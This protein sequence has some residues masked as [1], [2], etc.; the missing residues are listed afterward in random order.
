[1]KTSQ[2][3]TNFTVQKVIKLHTS[4]VE[5]SFPQNTSNCLTKSYTREQKIDEYECVALY[6][7]RLNKEHA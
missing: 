6:L 7:K 4:I 5:K 3:N 1:M 2:G